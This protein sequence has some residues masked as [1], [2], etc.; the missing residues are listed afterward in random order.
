M[1]KIKRIGITTG[2]GDAPG[3]N[4]VIRAVTKSALKRGWE[5]FGIRN[6]FDGV[7]Y[8]ENFPEGG[9]IPLDSNSVRG[10]AHIGGTILGT[11]NRGNPFSYEVKGPD[12]KPEKKNL[13][14]Q[15]LEGIKEAKLDAVVS[16]GGDGSMAIANEVAKLG[17]RVIGVP[18]TID[19]DLAGTVATFGFDTAVSFAT[20]A[21]GRLHLSLIH[22]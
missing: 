12:G 15:L 2:G 19:N 20:D 21:I 22:I 5:V 3:L 7:M 6:G 4:A 17:V 18:K 13:S 10:I 8:P 16:L 9:L 1:S 11:T 14:E